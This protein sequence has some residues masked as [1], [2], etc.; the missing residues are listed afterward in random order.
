[1]R[2]QHHPALIGARSQCRWLTVMGGYMHR[3]HLM[4]LSTG[5][6]IVAEMGRRK[7]G[8]LLGAAGK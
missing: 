1:M 8:Y 4:C 2:T 5:C 3:L 7:G 6:V